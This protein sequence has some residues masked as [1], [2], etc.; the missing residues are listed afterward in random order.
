[1][2]LEPGYGET[3]LPF[4]ELDALLPQVKTVLDE[5]IMRAAVYDLEQFFEQDLRETFL[6]VALEGDLTLEELLSSS[7]LVSLHKKMYG[8]IWNWAGRYRPHLL[9]I[10]VE[11]QYIAQ[12]IH[13]SLESI[14]VRWAQTRDWSTRELGI[15]VHA[16]CVRVHPFADGNGRSSRL[17]ADLVFVAAQDAENVEIYDWRPE[18]TDYVR[19]LREYDQH[20]NPRDLAALISTTA[21]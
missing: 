4:D 13:S 20:R 14:R 3:P 11:P 9:N 2:T 21:L 10:G 15:A 8:E 19:L 17:L 12:E 1:M 7:Y 5:P 18:K 6:T 16:E